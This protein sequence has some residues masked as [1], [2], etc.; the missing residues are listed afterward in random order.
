MGGLAV[1]SQGCDGLVS[2]HDHSC[3]QLILD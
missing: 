2:G 1:A 3:I